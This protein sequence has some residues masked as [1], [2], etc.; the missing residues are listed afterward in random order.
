MS[1]MLASETEKGGTG[2]AVNV[3]EARRQARTVRTGA[4]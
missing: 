3:S 2:A 1:A 4:V